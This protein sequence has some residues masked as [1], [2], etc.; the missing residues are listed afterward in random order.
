MRKCWYG[1]IAF[2]AVM[3]LCAAPPTGPEPAYAGIARQLENLIQRTMETEELPAFSIALVDDQKIV[4]ARGFGFADPD[5]K[6]PATEKTVYRVGSVSKLFTDIG[7]MQM[8]ERG[9]ID[10]DAPIQKYLPGF[11]VNN[12]F[13]AVPMTLRQLMSHR[14]GLLREPA[15]GHYFDPTEPTLAATVA[16][17][18]GTELVYAPESRTK[19]SNAGIAIVGHV[20][21][22]VAGQPFAPYL[23]QSVLEPLGLDTS[24]FQPLP[25]IQEQLARA[26][27]WTYDGQIFQAPRFELGMSPAGSMYSTVTDLG[28]FMSA[29]F[30]GGRG[31][32]GQVLR[33]ET[34]RSMWKPQY[35]QPGE[36][37][38]YG[39]G[40][41]L[42]NFEGR[43]SVGHNGAIYGFATGLE[44]LPDQKL[45]VVSVATMDSVNPV[46]SRVNRQALRLMLAARDGKPLPEVEMPT[47][48]PPG[49]A[50][51]LAGRYGEGNDAID[52]IED[53]D[54][55][56]E[57]PLAGGQQVE[58]RQSGNDLIADGRLGNGERFTITPAA[59][60]RHG[61]HALPRIDPRK[62][63]PI[64]DDWRGLIGE[65][66]WD[67]DVLYVL[68]RDA[69]LTVLIEWYDYYPL[70]EVSAGVFRFPDRG[71]Y[72]GETLRF[73]RD[74]TGRAT[75]ATVGAVVFPRRAVGPEAGGVF[76]IRPAR[77]VAEIEKAAR[78]ATPPRENGE[79]RTPDLVKL[80]ALD[81][82]IK[83]D[84]RYATS[85][86][87]LGTPVYPVARAFAQRPAA[88]AIARANKALQLLG[89]G[90]LIH[91]AYRPWFVT[92]VFWEATP[93][94]MRRFVADPSE[95]SRHNRGCAVDLTLYDLKTGQPIEM[96]GVYDEMSPRSYPKYPGGTALQRWHRDLLRRVMEREGF[97]VFEVEWWHFD[98]KD[99]RKYP[100][101][102]VPLE[103][104]GKGAT[105]QPAA[106]LDFRREP[107]LAMR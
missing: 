55:L 33:P 17:L 41:V 88:E 79:F 43:R 106:A 51:K 99:W 57:L 10:L 48:L 7:V 53:N 47:R 75:K 66:G 93:A 67:H 50:A 72:A 107:G 29:L 46:V 94:G 95:G 98:Y 86:N 16:S 76:R 30:A 64:R 105:A 71:L 15:V 35:A 58:L 68:E 52:L 102:N 65:Y 59:L 81:P 90:L 82:G 14:S 91:D 42:A 31:A 37:R 5:R 45:G 70:T 100:I 77:P 89:Y 87:F 44:A 83:L 18:N 22:R 73:E 28:S 25:A 38:G 8:V 61:S 96:P 85:R 11:H 54:R 13:D 23:K 26:F 20:L 40:F 84:I 60:H 78:A 39:L 49:L 104:L 4:W 19:Y 63:E 74:K 80:S 36:E 27:I 3:T 21:E 62:P 12:P 103:R 34:L 69:R 2:I 101:L 6:I 97:R 9:R 56:F 32:R 24:A 1:V 92:K